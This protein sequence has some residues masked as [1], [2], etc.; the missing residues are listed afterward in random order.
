M[1]ILSI[2]LSQT[3]NS[4]DFWSIIKTFRP[5]K[6]LISQTINECDW[7]EYFLTLLEGSSE[8]HVN[9]V[10]LDDDDAVNM[11]YN[12]KISDHEV[13]NAIN[14]LKNKKSC[15]PDGI[16][17]EFLKYSSGAIGILTEIFNQIFS[18]ALIPDQWTESFIVPIYKMGDKNQ[19]NN[20]RGVSLTSVLYKVFT[21]VL[22]ERLMAW[23]E[24]KIIFLN[25]KQALENDT[26][27]R[28]KSLF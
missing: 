27:P 19:V 12:S 7:R 11:S 14:K 28:T 5:R 13:Q 18:T 6:S 3:Q 2:S 17:G 9:L 4:T 26:V 24:E 20:Y 21:R 1:S 15:G 16:P 22:Y 23:T 8:R 10:D 25:V